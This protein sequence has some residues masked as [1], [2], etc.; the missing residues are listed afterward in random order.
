MGPRFARQLHMNPLQEFYQ[1]ASP[2]VVSQYLPRPG[3]VVELESDLQQLATV[4]AFMRGSPC[5][6]AS[7]FPRI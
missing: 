4:S 3:L 7:S 5:F 1:N 6:D 2:R